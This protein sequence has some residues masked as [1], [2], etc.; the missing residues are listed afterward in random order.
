MVKRDYVKVIEGVVVCVSSHS[1]ELFMNN[2][3]T[4]IRLQCINRIIQ[5]S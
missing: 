4:D 5:K 3:L 2:Q 1:S